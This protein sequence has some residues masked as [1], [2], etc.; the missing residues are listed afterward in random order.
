MGVRWLDDLGPV[1]R[2]LPGDGL[3][4]GL[5][6]LHGAA[7]VARHALQE[8]QPGLLLQDRVGRAARVARHVLLQMEAKEVRL[9][10]MS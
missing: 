1:G 5:D 6:G 7:R 2:P 4:P 8:E 9:K 3:E 10:K